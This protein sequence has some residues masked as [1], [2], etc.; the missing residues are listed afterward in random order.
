MVIATRRG[1]RMLWIVGGVLMGVVVLK[2]FTVD[3]SGTGTIA[4]IIGFITVGGLLLIVGYFAPVPPKKADLPEQQDAPSAVNP[5]VASE[6]P[7][8]GVTD[9][10]ATK[11]GDSSDATN[12]VHVG[13]GSA[14]K[15]DDNKGESSA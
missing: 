3:M 4:R 11:S 14:D 10:S 1:W 5:S 15:L 13:T 6:N 7:A 12:D 9:G 8:S 2:L